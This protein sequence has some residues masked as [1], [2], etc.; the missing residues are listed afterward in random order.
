MGREQSLPFAFLRD[1]YAGQPNF[2]DYVS[3]QSQPVEGLLQA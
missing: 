3:G 2:R 1:E